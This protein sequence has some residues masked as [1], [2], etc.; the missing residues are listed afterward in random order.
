[1]SEVGFEP[2]PPVETATLTQRLRPLGHPDCLLKV[3]LEIVLQRIA[4][5]CKQLS[6][7]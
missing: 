7:V 6:T 5:F 4:H 3:I 2:T 1:M